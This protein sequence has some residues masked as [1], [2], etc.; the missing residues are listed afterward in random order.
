MTD[1]VR[2][3]IALE[4]ICRVLR[5]GR[6]DLSTEKSAQADIHQLLVRELPPGW[7]VERE[8]RLSAHDIPDFVIAGQVVVEV[9]VKRSACGDVLGQLRRYARHE[10]ITG[11]IVA[12]NRSLVAPETLGGKPLR[13]VSLGRAWL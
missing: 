3:P 9:K 5:S 7:D 13:F 10:S 12:T 6:F 11:L 2:V 8:V 4:P 1:V